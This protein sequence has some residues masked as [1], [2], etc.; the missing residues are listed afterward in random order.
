MTLPLETDA[1]DLMQSVWSRLRE[2]SPDAGPVLFTVEP[3]PAVDATPEMSRAALET[4]EPVDASIPPLND[5][6]NEK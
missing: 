3:T 1:R 5:V 6:I 2:A 4:P